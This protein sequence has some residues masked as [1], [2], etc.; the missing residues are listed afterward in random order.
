MTPN[1][2]IHR[3]FGKYRLMLIEVVH[4]ELVRQIQ[5]LWHADLSFHRA[6]AKSRAGSLNLNVSRLKTLAP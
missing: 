3:I 1:P 2:S 5:A 6:S 4:Y